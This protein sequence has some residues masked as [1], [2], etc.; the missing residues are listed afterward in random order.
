MVMTPKAR[1]KRNKSPV[2]LLWVGGWVMGGWGVWMRNFQSPVKFF[3]AM[4][5]ATQWYIK[6]YQFN[7]SRN[8]YNIYHLSYFSSK[9]CVDVPCSVVYCTSKQSRHSDYS[10]YSVKQQ[11]RN[12]CN[13]TSG[14]TAVTDIQVFT[15]IIVI[16]TKPKIHS[17]M[18]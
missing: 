5:N 12:F 15:I 11:S 18:S 9:Y 16:L 14:P 3:V 8:T 7:W 4:Q 1:H 2:V 6:I 10:R 17:L 13:L